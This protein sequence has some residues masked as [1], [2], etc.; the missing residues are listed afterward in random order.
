MSEMKKPTDIIV[1]IHRELEALAEAAVQEQHA[2]ASRVDSTLD[3]YEDE[4][5]KWIVAKFK[6]EVLDEN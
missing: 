4:F 2:D 6:K 3:Y 1:D 5:A